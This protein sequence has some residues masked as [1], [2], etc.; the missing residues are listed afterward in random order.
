MENNI[1]IPYKHFFLNIYVQSILKIWKRSIIY[2][3][4]DLYTINSV[5]F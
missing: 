3:I 1:S 2:Y 4:P 5:I